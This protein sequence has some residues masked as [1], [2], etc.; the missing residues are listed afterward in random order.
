[1]KINKFSEKTIRNVTGFEFVIY[2]AVHFEWSHSIFKNKYNY[3]F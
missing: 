3:E 2:F 1:M